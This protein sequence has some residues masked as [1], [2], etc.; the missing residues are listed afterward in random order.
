ML[1]CTKIYENIEKYIKIYEIYLLLQEGSGS[2]EIST[3]SGEKK[4]RIRILTTTCIVVCCHDTF[5]RHIFS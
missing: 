2:G 3:G 1:R 5:P 4:Y